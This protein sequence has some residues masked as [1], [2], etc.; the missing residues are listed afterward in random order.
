MEV[1]FE[2]IYQVN[3]NSLFN[4]KLTSLLSFIHFGI[5]KKLALMLHNSDRKRSKIVFAFAAF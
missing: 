2:G 4:I 5:R 3:G 1:K